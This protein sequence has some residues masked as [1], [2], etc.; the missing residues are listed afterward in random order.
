MP[1]DSSGNYTLPA[2][3]PVVTGTTITSTWGNTTMNDLAS[4]MTDS[5]SRSGKGSM[6]ATMKI[7]DGTVGAPGLAFGSEP[8][9]GYYRIGVGNTGFAI[10]GVKV[11]DMTNGRMAFQS[12]AS[13]APSITFIAELLTGLYLKGAGNPVLQIGGVDAL[14]M[15]AFTTNFYNSAV[16]GGASVQV[17]NTS[18]VAGDFARLFVF[19]PTSNV[20]LRAYNTATAA[21]VVTGGPT[22]VQSILAASGTNGPLIFSVNGNLNAQVSGVSGLFQIV[23]APGASPGV[24]DAGYRDFVDNLQ[25]VNYGLILTDRG[26]MIRHSSGAA[27]TWTIPA[28]AGIAFPIGATIGFANISGGGAITIA[29][30]TDTLVWAPSGTT[31]S[32][33]LTGPGFATAVK[34]GATSWMIQGTGLS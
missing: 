11:L 2:G 8:A 12:G 16:T 9:T 29:I 31:G 18:T 23:D 17:G 13:G 26:K 21:P 19:T 22:G 15:N 4:E 10:G 24:F 25:N 3:N 34:V 1:R 20:A 14:S 28:N 32:R 6:N 7:F 30:T 33:T 27:H 5:L